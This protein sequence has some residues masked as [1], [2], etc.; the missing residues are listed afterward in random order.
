MPQLGCEILP[1]HLAQRYH[2]RHNLL[3]VFS[4][5]AILGIGAA[6]LSMSLTSLGASQNQLEQVVA[7]N[8]RKAQLITI[9]R[10]SLRERLLGL[11][12]LIY[13]TDPFKREEHWEQFI[14][15]ASNFMQA[16]SELQSLLLHQAE[17][18]L[19][20]K[21]RTLTATGQPL[22]H[23]VAEK[24][25]AGETD[26]AAH[27]ILAAE[28]IN[29]QVMQ[30]LDELRQLQ[31]Q[32]A[33]QAVT[34]ANIEYQQTR[35]QTWGL[36]ALSGIFC[37]LI[38]GLVFYRVRCQQ[39]QLY[40][41]VEA[42]EE[43]RNTL[44]HRVKERTAELSATN[45]RL[46]EEIQERVSAEQQLTFAAYYDHLTQLPNR[47]LLREHLA[48]I[49]H[50]QDRHPFA[51]LF[52]DLDR[53]KHVNDSLGHSL[54]DQLLHQVAKRL[55]TCI[56]KSDYLARW[57]GDEFVALIID[58]DPMT[59]AQTI[60][61]TLLQQLA[62]PFHI[63]SHEIYLGASI[64]I[65]LY[66]EHGQDFEMLLSH[67]DIAMYR[68]KQKGD[69]FMLYQPS[70]K[71]ASQHRLLLEKD[72]RRALEH[73]E[74]S[75]EYQPQYNLENQRITGLEALLRWRDAQGHHISPATFIPLAE[76]TGLIIPIGDWVL[77]QVCLQIQVWQAQELAIVPV[78]VNLSAR[79]FQD[80]QLIDKI[81]HLLR[82]TGVEPELLVIELT[83]SM[84]M[85]NPLQAIEILEQLAQMGIQIA[86][87][88]F[89]TG[90]S[91][92]SYLK[93][94]P[95]S[96][97]KIDRSFIR[98]LPQDS[99]DATI[100]NCI[101]SLARE[102][103][104]SVVAE[105]VENDA[106]YQFFKNQHYHAL[107]VQGFLFSKPLSCQETTKLLHKQIEPEQPC[108]CNLCP[109]NKKHCKQQMMI[110]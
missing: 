47:R 99:N 72:L 105:G 23:Q 55:H 46:Q 41:T 12:S 89:G 102:L 20:N 21:N 65:S 67:A 73:Q 54:G 16:R 84:V 6:T 98:E 25:K 11:F 3:I 59:A 5:L 101:V 57:G 28:G 60:S 85:S 10:E 7:E 107:D 97:L 78:A 103:G 35:R 108:L 27:Y 40:Q 110:S 31:H 4:C 44:E 94:L 81:R 63:D 2:L 36:F 42:L 38:I 24:A 61:E 93:R 22:L 82:E 92:L 87:D 14:F 51:V 45:Q 79:Q 8:Q 39:Q 48:Q 53:F 33:Q 18:T 13:Q 49:I 76:E 69:G 95:V 74:F 91:S 9:M 32:A 70:M 80:Q 71:Q 86:V 17:Q 75:I 109:A 58:Q 62:Q 64:G 19:L 68:A 15:N 43:A 37:A 106:Q 1:V 34:T 29:S 66:P 104:L 96:K 77:R 83:E 90:Y 30:Q 56:A 88:D 100:S 52:I 26:A 50:Q